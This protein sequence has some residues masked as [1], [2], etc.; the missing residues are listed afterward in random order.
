MKKFHYK[1]TYLIYTIAFLLLLPLLLLQFIREGKT[2]VWWPDGLYQHLPM[3]VYYGGLLRDFL[4]GH[5]FALMD[6]RLGLGFDTITTLNYYV[7]GDP[8][9]LFSVFVTKEN[10]VFLYGLLILLR[11]YLAGISFILFMKYW[12]RSGMAVALGAL[13]Y[14]FNGYTLFACLR[15]PFFMNPLIY[16]PLLLI[17]AEQVLRR[18]KPYLLIVMTSISA[19]SNFY[20]FFI[21]SVITVIYIIFRYIT[22]YRK[23]YKSFFGG[24]VITGLKTGGSY[25]LGVTLAAFL[26]LPVVYA[27]LNNGR[28]GA[29]PKLLTSYFAYPPRYYVALVKGF[30][31]TESYTGFWTL[32]S[33]PVAVIVSLAILLCDKKYWKLHITYV[34]ILGGLCVPVFG[35]F[36]NGFSYVANRWGFIMGLLVAITFSLTYEKIFVLD[37]K[38]IILLLIG[39]VGYGMAVFLFPSKHSVKVVFLCLTVS[40]L[41][42]LALQ[43]G[44]MK[45]Q[46]LFAQGIFGGLVL[47]SL[48]INGYFL[49]SP[50]YGDYV[51]EFDSKEEVEKDSYG[52]V[53][54]LLSEIED[55]SF[56]RV[57]TYNDNAL[58]EALNNEKYD[59][60]GYYSLMDGSVSSYLKGLEDLS[61]ISAYRFDDMDNRTILNTLAGV[62]YFAT[63]TKAAVP[64]GY[65]LLK[66]IT[67]G[68]KSYYLYQNNYALPLGYAYGS[69]MLSGDYEQLS[70]LEKQSAMLSSVI[71]DGATSYAA[72]AGD[73]LDYGVKKL[74]ASIKA[75]S[76]VDLSED[77]L[78]IKNKD[79]K[80]TFR[81]EAAPDSEIYVR[82][83]GLAIN[84]KES[85]S[86]PFYAVADTGVKKKV[87]VRNIYYNSYFGK[88]NY[89]I[90]TGQSTGEE[91]EIELSFPEKQSFYYKDLEVYSVDMNYY[92]NKI[93]ELQK[94]T[95]TNLELSNNR[96]Q[97]DITLEQSK[98]LVLSI[99]YS[100][101]WSAYV[102]G[103]KTELLRGNIM[104]MALPL[105]A[106][107]HHI[108]LKYKTPMLRLGLL[109]SAL[110]LAVLLGAAVYRR[111]PKGVCIHAGRRCYGHFFHS[112]YR[113]K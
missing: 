39:L 96:I 111:R 68:K 25:L 71:L 59:V 53:W 11:F 95:L 93:K 78:I 62:K 31:T 49:L 10:S 75:D 100:K 64:Y 28:L 98:V 69:Y 58:N 46:P 88:E 13:I 30:F 103:T 2:F 99:P 27:F 48:V 7:L 67:S 1:N 24:L 66:K 21:L 3:L 87:V 15:H 6:F 86:Y 12:K 5:G 110:T 47:V 105:E 54:S 29:G 37:R 57:D 56:Y 101:G 26:F 82:L 106:G 83:G 44:F 33:F 102:D 43:S 42:I 94:D 108:I 104:Y 19:F 52:G 97:G 109:I 4:L 91:Q 38:E 84:K 107:S 17:G 36:M 65:T 77:R 32:L 89:L 23:E 112:K 63:K 16:L 60:S 22:L 92:E 72:E 50:R 76:G 34:L 73:N 14:V 90:N 80:I 70:A 61:Q 45:K 55:T 9:T 81:F 85:I 35:Y 41:I 51:S 113:K 18:R 40:V 8:I 74:E 79:A 20:F